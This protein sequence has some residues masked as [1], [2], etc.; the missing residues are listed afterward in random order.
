MSFS[1]ILSFIF[2]FFGK[3]FSTVLSSVVSARL[4]SHVSRLMSTSP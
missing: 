4:T 3:D 2:L 1:V